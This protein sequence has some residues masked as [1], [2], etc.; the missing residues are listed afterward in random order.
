MNKSQ[1]LK[2]C[3]ELLRHHELYHRDNSPEISDVEFDQRK[4]TLI[5][6]EK[7]HPEDISPISP[8]QL[9]GSYPISGLK[10]VEHRNKMLSLKNCFSLEDL[11]IFEQEVDSALFPS[12]KADG[13]ALKLI[14]KNKIFTQ[15]CTRGD[16]SVGEDVTH[17]A[18][19]MQGIPLKLNGDVPNYFE[20]NGEA[21]LTRKQ[22][23]LINKD[24]EAK[25]LKLFVNCRNAAAGVFRLTDMK[26]ARSRKLCFVAYSANDYPA[27]LTKLSEVFDYLEEQGFQ[28]TRIP[29]TL[30][31]GDFALYLD[32]VFMLRKSL[33]YDTDG[34]VFAVDQFKKQDQIGFATDH[35]KFAI[36]YKFSPE[37]AYTTV[38]AIEVQVGRTG[39]ITPVAKIKPVFVSGVTVANVTLHNQD[40]IDRLDLRIGDTVR[41][42][43]AGEV[44][45]EIVAVVKEF[46]SKHLTQAPV[47]KLPTHCPSCAS[48]L[49]KIH[50]SVK[51]YCLNEYCE[52]RTIR[53]IEY[54]FS[55]DV[56]DV[57][58]FGYK[59]VEK[60]VQ[61]TLRNQDKLNHSVFIHRPL[62]WMQLI[63]L[64]QY[65]KGYLV[66]AKVC[67]EER[68][69]ELLASL[70]SV[71]QA[72]KAQVYQSL[73]LPGLGKQSSIELAQH[74]DLFADINKEQIELA[75]TEGY[76][77]I[78]AYD[79]LIAWFN[80]HREADCLMLRGINALG[81][82]PKVITGPLTGTT[83]CFTGNMEMGK[84]KARELVLTLG[85]KVVESVNKE[86]THVVGNDASTAK[87]KKAV[88]LGKI[89]LDEVGFLTLLKSTKE[90]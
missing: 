81:I 31:E 7:A 45:P 71:R 74:L 87:F 33:D 44:I 43:R 50:E 39:A 59:Q 38:Y 27:R 37:E 73:N 3:E 90:N 40:E 21:I 14:Y 85:A 12:F 9:V 48:R 56:L 88:K 4:L 84:H 24:R 51:L 23:E 82:V 75:F 58:G 41:V 61:Y 42:R 79:S 57:K 67:S 69:Q 8:S 62:R 28:T 35:P 80:T 2:E 30:D 1:Y 15:A 47:F 13:L 86:C 89:T 26:E 6:Y 11:Q 53:A 29:I 64:A 54:A 10:E 36:A 76:L 63:I 5:A 22:F 25:K 20:V 78:T 49:E 46:R 66:S 70:Y 17:V 19:V 83:F 55:K 34:V 68:E 65:V 60:L 18:R 16:G 52:A 32:R 72:T 77:D